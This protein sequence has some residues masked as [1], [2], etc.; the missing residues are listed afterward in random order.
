MNEENIKADE[1]TTNVSA[2]DTNEDKIDSTSI[3]N[4]KTSEDKM[5]SAG[6]IEGN[7][8]EKKMDSINVSAA[9]T[10]ENKINNLSTPVIDENKDK[11]STEST[12]PIDLSKVKIRHVLRE[13]IKKR[14]LNSKKIIAFILVG[15]ICFGAGFF[16]GTASTI[17]KLGRNFYGKPG[18]TR[19]MH[20]NFNGNKKFKAYPNDGTQAPQ[21]G[22]SQAPAQGQSGS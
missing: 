10:D 20:R 19:N 17:H 1:V 9:D 8:S 16:T 13:K 6:I 2:T 18:I 4:G 15:V 21:Q 7:T 3:I 14:N 22:Q 11:I 5:D 12:S